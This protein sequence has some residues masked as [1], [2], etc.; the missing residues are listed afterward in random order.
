MLGKIIQDVATH[1]KKQ[2]HGSFDYS[3]T[4]IVVGVNAFVHHVRL[5]L[6]SH[7][8]FQLLRESIEDGEMGQI[9]KIKADLRDFGMGH[10]KMCVPFFIFK[11]DL[12]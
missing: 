12:K 4:K 10:P 1:L 3:V 6:D 9:Y 8:N 7:I 5:V 11:K 2:Y